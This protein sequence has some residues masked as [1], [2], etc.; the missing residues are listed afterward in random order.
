MRRPE[1]LDWI[2]LR[3]HGEEARRACSRCETPERLKDA[4][5]DFVQEPTTDMKDPNTI[6]RT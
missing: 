6:R 3:P 1:K 5:S 4:P 2:L